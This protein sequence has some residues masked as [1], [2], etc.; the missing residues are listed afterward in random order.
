MGEP[1]HHPNLA[2][3]LES[4]GDKWRSKTRDALVKLRTS[5]DSD[6]SIEEWVEQGDMLDHMLGKKEAPAAAGEQSPTG[7]PASPDTEGQEIAV[8]AA[9]DVQGPETE[10]DTTVPNALYRPMDEATAATIAVD[11]ETVVEGA[12]QSSASAEEEEEEEEEEEGVPATMPAGGDFGI[13]EVSAQRG[14]TEFVGSDPN[15]ALPTPSPADA[16]GGTVVGE[17]FELPS[18]FTPS[19]DPGPGPALQPAPPP[20]RR[21]QPRRRKPRSGG[22]IGR[23]LI[24]AVVVAVVVVGGALGIGQ[25]ASSG[26]E[27]DEIEPVGN[28]KSR[29]GKKKSKKTQAQPPPPP[30]PII[31]PNPPPVPYEPW[32][33]E[34]K[35]QPQP[36]QPQ[37]K[38]PQPKQPQPKQPQPKT[39]PKQPEPKPEPKQPDPGQP[40]PWIMPSVFPP[41]PG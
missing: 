27:S 9:D 6:P 29:K 35:K 22:G 34:P 33:P 26:D 2:Q 41:L 21:A 18:A 24:A 36:A 32:Q 13:P 4:H 3:A 31:P 23:I 30:E 19:A 16:A 14:V 7:Q 8:Q 25:L 37:P 39:D 12:G 20:A 10:D 40:K 28:K 17:P 1:K 38:Q 5:F 11:Q 15:G